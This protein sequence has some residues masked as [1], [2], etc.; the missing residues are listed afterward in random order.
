M[1][2][3]GLFSLLVIVLLCLCPMLC[4]KVPWDSCPVKDS[5]FSQRSNIRPSLHLPGEHNSRCKSVVHARNIFDLSCLKENNGGLNN[6]WHV[7]M[8]CL[9][10][11]SQLVEFA[12]HTSSACGSDCDVVV[13]IP[14]LEW[15]YISVLFAFDTRHVL[16]V[17]KN[18]CFNTGSD[19]F[20]TGEL[21]S[22]IGASGAANWNPAIAQ[23][24]NITAQILNTRA[25][26]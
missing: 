19:A 1:G 20:I 12:E 7:L 26:K 18:D 4:A 8:E 3:H 22:M 25:Q 2:G 17:E 23:A 13:L 21:E 16:V 24:Y 10:H 6:A 11:M 5:C 9:L 15:K 14:I